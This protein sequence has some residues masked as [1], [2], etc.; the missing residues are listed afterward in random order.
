MKKEINLTKEDI[1]NLLNGKYNNEKVC[2]FGITHFKYS[3][4]N[5]EDLVQVDEVIRVHKKC[6]KAFDKMQNAAKEDKIRIK[7]VSGYRSSKYQIDIFKR[8]FL[9]KD[10]PTEKELRQRL[11]FSAPSGFSEHHTGLAIDINSNSQNFEK[12]RAY[13]W[14]AENANKYGFEMSFPR[15]CRQNLGFE[16]WHWRYVGDKESEKIFNKAKM[17]SQDI[18]K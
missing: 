7:I 16:P 5:E 4:C 18:A 6:K 15:K 2:A 3:D 8:K 12:S 10:N 1:S 14:L 13:K 11:K 17:F 9:N